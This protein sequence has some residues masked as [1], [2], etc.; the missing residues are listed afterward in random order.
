MSLG[1]GDRTQRE[2]YRGSA[3]DIGALMR[4]IEAHTGIET[5][6]AYSRMHSFVGLVVCSDI[7]L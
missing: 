6:G 7:V 3:R 2:D 4:K 1:T 5:S